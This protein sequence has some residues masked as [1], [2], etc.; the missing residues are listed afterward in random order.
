[1]N[2][3][4]F[5]LV[6]FSFAVLPCT[7]QLRPY[8]YA[9]DIRVNTLLSSQDR[10]AGV[11]RLAPSTELVREEPAGS[12]RVVVL[13][14][15]HLDAD[16]GAPGRQGVEQFGEWATPHRG[17][18]RVREDEA[19]R[20]DQTRIAIRRFKPSRPL[21]NN[22]PVHLRQEAGQVQENWSLEALEEEEGGERW[23]LQEQTEENWLAA[24]ESVSSLQQREEK[25]RF[26]NELKWKQAEA[27][28]E[29]HQEEES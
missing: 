25:T 12:G 1:M 13:G 17:D 22:N 27:E 28:G 9:N 20:Q 11:R 4:K 16:Q 19:E 18:V 3:V 15:T 5:S 8:S 14:R 10:L 24:Q 23:G 7:S 21:Q 26:Y 6:L 29:Q 2:L